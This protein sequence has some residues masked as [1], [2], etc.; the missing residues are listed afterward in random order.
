MRIYY[1]F[2]YRFVSYGIPAWGHGD[3]NIWCTFLCMKSFINLKCMHKFE[4]CNS[5]LPLKQT[6]Y[7]HNMTVSISGNGCNL[8]KITITQSMGM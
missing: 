8:Y 4:L 7:L 5:K 2:L 3:K 6:P 1:G